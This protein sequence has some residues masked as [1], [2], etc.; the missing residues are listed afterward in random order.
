MCER[1]ALETHTYTGCTYSACIY[2]QE[3]SLRFVLKIEINDHVPFLNLRII[4]NSNKMT[5]GRCRNSAHTA[6]HN[7]MVT[8]PSH[9]HMSFL[10]LI[11]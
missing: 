3:N 1:S 6:L 9:I 4:R 11:P 8:M 7:Q 2:I 10:S 5:S